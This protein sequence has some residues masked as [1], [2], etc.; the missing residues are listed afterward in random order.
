MRSCARSLRLKRANNG[1]L[2]PAPK[3][4]AAKLLQIRRDLGISQTEMVKRLGL[5]IAYNFISKYELNKNEPPLTVLLRY[6]SV[7]GCRVE[8]LIDDNIKP[9]K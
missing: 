3:H 7:Y 5:E 1:I 6:A 2:P 9:P 4:L 8:E